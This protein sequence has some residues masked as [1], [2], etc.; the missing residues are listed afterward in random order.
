MSDE[1]RQ[2]DLGDDEVEVSTVIL[3]DED[4]NERDFIILSVLEHEGERYAV[5]ESVETF[6][7]EEEDVEPELVIMKIAVDEEGDEILEPVQDDAI[8]DAVFERFASEG[9]DLDN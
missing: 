4:G 5:L 1:A 7:A 8:A 9:D 3:V 6:E 2:G